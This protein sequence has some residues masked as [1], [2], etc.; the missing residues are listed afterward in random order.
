[1]GSNTI[2]QASLPGW[3]GR[4]GSSLRA[5]RN[6]LAQP[7]LWIGL[8]S[9][10]LIVLIRAQLP[11]HYAIDVGYEE[12]IGSDL[13]FL[14]GFNTAEQSSYGSYRWT[15]DGATIRF[16]GVGRRP[17]ALELRFLTVNAEVMAKGPQQ[18]DL[19]SEGHLLASLPVRATGSHQ[20]VLVPPTPS[21]TLG[22]TLHTAT[23]TP[24]SDPRRLGTPLDA[25]S[26]SPLS[27]GPT[28]PD[29]QAVLGWLGAAALVWM[30]LRHALGRDSGASRLYGTFILLAGLAALL[31]PPRWAAGATAALIAAAIA[32]PLAIGL[33]AGLP[34]LA[35]RLGV[36]L[37]ASSLGWLVAFCVIAFMMRYG[38]RL[39]PNSMHGD[40]VF[41]VNRFTE[42][43]TGQIFILSKNR[44]VD[45]PYPPGP[46]ILIAPL[47]LTGL[48]IRTVLQLGAA[49]ADALSAVVVY[50]IASRVVRP[51]TALLAAATYVFTAATLMTTWWSFDTHIYSQFLHLLT[52]AGFCWAIEAWQGQDRGRRIAWSIGVFVLLSTVFLGHFGFLINT[53]LLVGM[54]IVGTWLMSWRGAGWARAIRWP[55]TLA[56]GGAV[57]FAGVCFYSAY[58][59]LFLSQIQTA[60][61]SGFSAVAN[62]TPAN[63]AAMWEN[64]WRAG[65]ITHFGIFPIPLALFGVWRLARGDAREESAPGRT[66]VLALMFGSLVVAIC[67]A[68]LPFITL[69]TNSPRWLMF[70]A[71]VVALGTAISVEEIW[72]RGWVGKLATLAMGAVVLANTAWIWLAPM[73]WR[74][75]PPEPF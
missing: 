14:Q 16:R 22:I 54:L 51:Q 7:S 1:M 17:L 36:P 4:L 35:H 69:A 52:I 71:W 8:T 27:T 44:G 75:R 64:L 74:V 42:G 49:L 62:R 55:L 43:L 39:Y 10:L 28:A 61:T 70:I 50:A 29:W 41:H 60:S 23:F 3:P 66:A 21:G 33:R 46:Y 40:I 57:I 56:Y 72:R 12:G 53:A 45:F 47:T 13:P 5:E 25:I 20:L 6:N 59:P 31:D 65:L 58:I 37:E 15:D 19:Y 73:L 2:T 9:L 63:R 30:A 24:A 67:F 18:I 48:Q 38:G 68:V 26:I 34:P 11:L 32:Y